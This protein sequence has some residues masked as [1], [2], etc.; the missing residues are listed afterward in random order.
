LHSYVIET[1][2]LSRSGFVASSCW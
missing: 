1:N 2:P